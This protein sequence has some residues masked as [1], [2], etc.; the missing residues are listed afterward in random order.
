MNDT[1]KKEID[2]DVRMLAAMAYG[3]AD[4]G[5][6]EQEMFAIASVLERQRCARGFATI[7][8]LGTK[9]K[10]FSFVTS[11]GNPRY[12]KLK[13]AS[14]SS[15]EKDSGMKAAIAAA[16]NAKS[17]GVDYSNGAYFWDGSDIK[18]NYSTHFKVR[19]GIRF[20]NP[21]DNIYDIKESSKLV[22]LTKTIKKKIKGKLVTETTE[23]G[24]YDHI[25]ESTVA[26]GGTIFWKQADDYLKLT[27]SKP[28]L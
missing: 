27:K 2:A 5:N 21:D 16:N 12:A 14:E 19:H 9:D 15:I 1:T 18:K 24:R 7:T 13:N 8:E 17:G 28:Y 25:Y 23:I 26:H 3:E 11:D 22:I 6:N 20:P 4:T 10:S